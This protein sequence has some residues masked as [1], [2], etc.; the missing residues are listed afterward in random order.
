MTYK[1]RTRRTAALAFFGLAAALL[2][3]WS[4][5]G[6]S[7]TG[8]GN[9]SGALIRMDMNTTVGVLLDEFPPGEQREAAADWAPSKD[10]NFWVKRAGEQ[11]NLT[12]YRLVFRQFFYTAPPNRGAL[13]LPPRTIW[14]FDL[15]GDPY[16]T[17]IG[18]H[19]YVAANYISGR[20]WLLT[21]HRPARAS[22]P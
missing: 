1:D 6:Q 14:H 11:V 21:Q 10:E 8:S 9:P 5:R 4:A 19:D 2:L 17:H 3:P 12:Y 15:A 20:I 18:T 7:T 22:Q 16:R 13:P